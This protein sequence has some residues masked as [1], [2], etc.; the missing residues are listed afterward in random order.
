MK[1]SHTLPL[2]EPGL[3]A[4]TA[5][6][7]ASP[8]TEGM[9]A[10]DWQRPAGAAAAQALRSALLDSRQRWRDL[11]FMAADLAFE[12]DRDGRFQFVA[13]DPVL[14]WSADSLLGLRAEQMLTDTAQGAFNPFQ[15]AAP[16]R[17]RRAWVKRPDG[18]AACLSFAV[19]PLLDAGGAVIGVR[20]VAEDVTEQDAREAETAAALRRAELIDHVLARMRCE[21]LAPRMMRSAL[22]ALANASASEGAAVLDMIGDGIEPTILHSWGEA[23][24]SVVPCAAATLLHGQAGETRSG[25]SCGG[26]QILACPAH[27]R[28][29]EQVALVLWR[30]A[31]ARAWDR[32]DEML[33][34]AASTIVRVILEHDAIQRE[35][36][37]QA[38]TDPLSGLFNRRAFLDELARRIDRLER[39]GL[40]GAL[41]FIDLDNF[42]ELNDAAG[43]EAGDEALRLVAQLLR[44]KTRPSD[45][46]ARLGGDEFA[47]WLDG[48]DEFAASE[49]AEQLR[50]GTPAALAV[51]TDGRSPPISMSIGIASRWP[52]RGEDVDAL[53]N[54]ADQ[55]MYAVKRSGRG[56]WRLAASGDDA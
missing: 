3:V 5:A 44:G 20:G 56:H 38:R 6:E 22:E 26:R 24:P 45:L 8:R 39:E 52:G 48:A 25:T 35:M 17:G 46:L 49:R 29:G 11:V 31:G 47:V 50:E 37:R 30:P 14:G 23:A 33:I 1:A 19:A 43:H 54:R 9:A 27:T 7:T 42:K 2:V 16:A 53:L 13:P 36:A 41:L 28:F 55:A 51:V 40:P 32:D 21:V 34:A 12:T 4:A 15:A 10:A 18:S